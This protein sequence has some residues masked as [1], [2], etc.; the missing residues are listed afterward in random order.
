MTKQEEIH[1]FRNFVA[2]LPADAQ[3]LGSI[4]GAIEREAAD[5]IRN[6]FSFLS[7]RERLKEQRQHGKEV[8]ELAAKQN[9]LAAELRQLQRQRD[10]SAP[11]SRRQ[12]ARRCGCTRRY[13]AADGGA[14]TRPRVVG[15]S[16]APIRNE[17]R[18]VEPAGDRF[19]LTASPV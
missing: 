6:D 18:A 2:S 5:A 8:G 4:L 16:P 11:T 3:Y 10:R 7:P 1:L 15:A 19:N 17:H 12:S 9:E 13:R 14:K